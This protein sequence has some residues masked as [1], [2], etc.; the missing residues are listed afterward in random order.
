MNE[1]Q[2]VLRLPEPL[3]EP[4]RFALSSSKRRDGEDRQPSTFEVHFK[5]DRNAI[6]R[7]DDKEYPAYL[8][9]LPAIVETHKT[10][11]KRTFYKSGDLHQV[12]VVRMPNEPPP[13]NPL[14][15]DGLTPGS[16]Q[17]G[18][19]LAEPE[20]VFNAE[21]VQ[22]VEQRIK[23]VIDHKVKFVAKKDEPK[24][25]TEE[26]EVVIEEETTVN[27]TPSKQATGKPTPSQMPAAPSRADAPQ[28]P[29]IT[30]NVLTPAV[31][32]TPD[33]MPSPAA[34]TPGPLTPGPVTPGPVTPGPVTPG[35]VTP[36]PLTPA[37]ETP[38]PEGEEG[39][40][41]GDE[42][43]ED[44][45]DDDDDFADMAGALMEDEEEAAKKRILKNNLMQQIADA[46]TK[47]SQLE[48]RAAQAPNPVF[49]NR[50]LA[51]KPEFEAEM[52]EAEAKLAELG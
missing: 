14:L 48:A 40:G 23:Y 22:M 41:E 47:V 39:D 13:K 16:R 8:M 30:D 6:F 18:R 38:L 49:R 19:R 45:E 33:A 32:G 10:A 21:Q 26:E 52:K 46:K 4:M 20:R 11:D 2:Y 24:P 12:L 9:D 43:E 42:E 51:K 1:S 50:I 27:S 31:A 7:V 25:P 29:G 35:P 15:M 44:D 34:D 28:A 17:A 5:D 37:P 36:G 3:V